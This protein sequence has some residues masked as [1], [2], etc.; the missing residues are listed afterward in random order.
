MVFNGNDFNVERLN[1]HSRI[2]KTWKQNE[3]ASGIISGSCSSFALIREIFIA[4]NN[5]TITNYA[6][7]GMYENH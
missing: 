1:K 3:I 6:L 5:F 2:E 4:C 7:F